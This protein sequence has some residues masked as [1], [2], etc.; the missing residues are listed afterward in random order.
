MLR[1]S[2]FVEIIARKVSSS[3]R[4]IALCPAVTMGRKLSRAAHLKNSPGA[5]VWDTDIKSAR[6]GKL[7]LVEL[8]RTEL[9]SPPSRGYSEK[10]PSTFGTPSSTL[11]SAK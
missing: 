10:K 1:P 9:S 8:Y 11:Q 5:V 4:K 6:R 3:S 2:K 7:A